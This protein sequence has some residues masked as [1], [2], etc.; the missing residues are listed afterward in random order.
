MNI[1]NDAVSY[2]SGRIA[3]VSND[4]SMLKADYMARINSLE[5]KV[6]DLE[7][8]VIILTN[9]QNGTINLESMIREEVL[10]VLSNR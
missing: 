3:S 5:N 9:M 10:K 4:T 2:L 1:I 7:R 8:Q 6:R